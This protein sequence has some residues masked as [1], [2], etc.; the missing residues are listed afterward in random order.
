M[1]HSK[2]HSWILSLGWYA[3]RRF[4]TPLSRLRCSATVDLL[5]FSPVRFGVQMTFRA[6]VLRR[7]SIYT[8][9]QV[10]EE[11]TI[12]TFVYENPYSAYSVCGMWQRVN[13]RNVSCTPNFTGEKYAI[14]TRWSTYI[15][16]TRQRRK[17]DFFLKR[18]FPMFTL[19][20]PQPNHLIL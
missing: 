1:R 2:V 20:S 10:G 19:I 17:T 8:K 18:S 4:T 11:H 5:C 14:S 12:S 13:A 16:L 7:S 3:Y 9:P 15:Q 6:S